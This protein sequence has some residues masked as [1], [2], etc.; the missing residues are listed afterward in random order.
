MFFDTYFLCSYNYKLVERSLMFD[1]IKSTH[2]KYLMI[3]C[4]CYDIYKDPKSFEQEVIIKR[5][6]YVACLCYVFETRKRINHCTIPIVLG[7]YLDYRIRGLQAILECR[8]QWGTVILKGVLKIYAS[9]ST[10][11]ALS[12]H[13]RETK[14]VKSIDW[15]TYVPSPENNTNNGLAI[16]YRNNI[17]SWTYK[18]ESCDSTKS[19]EWIN[20][21]IKSN[22]F[23]DRLPFK[24][25]EVEYMQ[26]FD[27]IV[28]FR[29]I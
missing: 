20:L 23:G 8:A 12:M 18:Y 9:F 17:V 4:R 6:S 28:Q 11:D 3:D 14:K 10:F 22:P 16:N 21:L 25:H 27:R 2:S 29:T 15:F 5:K 19:N 1:R 13:I 26:M 24:N 7:S